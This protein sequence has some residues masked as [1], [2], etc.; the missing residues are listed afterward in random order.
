MRELGKI[1]IEKDIEMKNLN[2]H[3]SFFLMACLKNHKMKND[4]ISDYAEF[5]NGK[6]EKLR[7]ETTNNQT[8]IKGVK[9]EQLC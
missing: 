6:L 3:Y 1:I 5:V 7:I 2:Y 9:N 8:T 4:S